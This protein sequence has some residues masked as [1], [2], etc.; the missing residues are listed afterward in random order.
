M[1]FNYEN[2]EGESF[3]GLGRIEN[4]TKIEWSDQ[5]DL[6]DAL[7]DHGYNGHVIHLS[8]FVWQAKALRLVQVEKVEVPDGDQDLSNDPGKSESSSWHCV[9]MNDRMTQFYGELSTNKFELCS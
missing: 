6:K 3:R 2:K 9:L 7:E 1:E 5:S 8:Q 4:F